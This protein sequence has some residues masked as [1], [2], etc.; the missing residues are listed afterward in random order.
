MLRHFPFTYT[1]ARALVMYSGGDRGNLQSWRP[2]RRSD[3]VSIEV[4][5]FTFTEL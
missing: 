5:H 1:L 4:V 3:V 2:Y